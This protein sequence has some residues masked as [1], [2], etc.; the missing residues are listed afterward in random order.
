MKT[1]PTHLIFDMVKDADNIYYST[2]NQVA[3]VLAEIWSVLSAFFDIPKIRWLS[4]V[5]AEFQME[6]GVLHRYR[7]SVQNSKTKTG[8]CHFSKNAVAI[9]VF[10][11]FA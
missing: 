3:C 2:K 11:T 9:I 8:H 6:T 10:L 5:E 7:V 4:R 1:K